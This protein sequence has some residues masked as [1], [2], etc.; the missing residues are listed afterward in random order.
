M[1]LKFASALL[2]WL[3]R[4]LLIIMIFSIQLFPQ[5]IH[6]DTVRLHLYELQNPSLTRYDDF[7]IEIPQF[8]PETAYDK[9]SIKLFSSY[10]LSTMSKEGFF[11]ARTGADILSNYHK[12]YIEN[13]KINPVKYILGMAQL[14]AVG[15]LAYRHI[16][17]H[18][19]K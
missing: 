2:K 5:E 19:F 17:K 11:Y 10:L 7:T 15:Y 14:G 13:S 6:K 8:I 9:E 16:K 4:S 3:A 1:N 12:I 18:G